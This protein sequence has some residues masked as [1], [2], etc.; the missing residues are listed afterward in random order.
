MPV[1]AS[2]ARTPCP[3]VTEGSFP[4]SQELPCSYVIAHWFRIA[5]KHVSAAPRGGEFITLGRQGTFAN[6][7]DMHRR[8][9]SWWFAWPSALA[10]AL[11][12]ERSALL[13]QPLPAP[14]RLGSDMT[15][16]RL[17]QVVEAM[18]KGMPK[19]DR[20]GF[21]P[22]RHALTIDSVTAYRSGVLW[23]GNRGKKSRLGLIPRDVYTLL[24]KINATW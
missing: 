16:S 17:P 1:Q 12:P 19:R 2:S 3:W 23:V 18:A 5:A 7:G 22:R 11:L 15:S 4:V 20:V 6:G 10:F 14:S 9:Y 8:P 24:T 13:L 21:R